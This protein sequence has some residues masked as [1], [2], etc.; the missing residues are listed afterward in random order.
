MAQLIIYS[1]AFILVAI[2][3]EAARSAINSLSGGYIRSLEES[4]SIKAETWLR[5]KKPYSFVLR[6][7]SF[8]ITIAFS[9]FIYHISFVD[10]IY[11]FPHNGLQAVKQVI[12][13]ILFHALYLISRETVGAIWIS[14]YRYSLLKFSIPIINILRVIMKPYELILIN[15]F[16]KAKLRDEAD[17]T[18]QD[19]STEHEILSLVENDVNMEL[20]D[21]ERRMIKGVFDLNDKIVKEAMTPR[22][23][24]IGINIEKS[25]E[26]AIQLLEETNFSR[27]PVYEENMDN[28]IGMIYFKDF[29]K[30][31][32][33]TEKPLK[34]FLHKCMLVPKT[35]PLDELLEE[36]RRTQHHMAI[37]Q[38]DWGGTSGLIT[39]E[40]ILE[41]IVGEIFDEY[42]ELGSECEISCLGNG[43]Y[44]LDAKA[45]IDD[46]NKVLIEDDPVLPFD[47]HF[48]TIGGYIYR[49]V[50]R[51]PVQG[52]AIELDNY[53][54]KVLEADERSILR[55][56]L[57]KIEKEENLE[58]TKS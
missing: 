6:S 42:D 10:P 51:I 17:Q 31:K 3:L 34:D 37:V 35:T 21:D 18:E 36:F 56:A 53:I 49:T 28:I 46:I 15:S 16:E 43:E 27:M 14:Y 44:I 12:V 8:I 41:E 1:L 26:E 57:S 47:E 38:D 39:I 9:C 20:E 24:V 5:D 7:L 58:D 2:W 54:A 13:F 29:L 25:A 11:I 45:T 55:V 19:V 33:I 22:T 52:E 50:S 4:K 40:D 30:S 48:D 32:D 23:D